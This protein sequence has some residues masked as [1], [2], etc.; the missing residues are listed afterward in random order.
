M[1]KDG[2]ITIPQA[3]LALL[4]RYKPIVENELVEVTLETA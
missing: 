3:T 2:C 1:R 4:S